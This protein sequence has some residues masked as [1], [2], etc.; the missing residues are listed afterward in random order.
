MPAYSGSLAP[1]RQ[2]MNV[3]S[4]YVLERKLIESGRNADFLWQSPDDWGPHLGKVL[5]DWI[6]EVAESLA[7]AIVASIAVIDVETVVIDGAFPITV[8][9]AIIERTRA[10]L[11]RVNRQGLS[12]FVLAEGVLGSGARAMGG[13]AIPLL[14]NFTRD[15]EVLFKENA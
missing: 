8:R 2:L 14:A 1:T 11:D 9:Q 15:R 12:P 10:V 6:E 7:Y 5:D 3:A 4:I 13:A